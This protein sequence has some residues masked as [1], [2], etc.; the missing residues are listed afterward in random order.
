MLAIYYELDLP[1]I[2]GHFDSFLFL[3]IMS[4]TP[5]PIQSRALVSKETLYGY[6]NFYAQGRATLEPG[7]VFDYDTASE[8]GDAAVS[9]DLNKL[10]VQVYVEDPDP[11]SPTYGYLIDATAVSLIGFKQDGN[12]RVVN[13]HT[14][15][16]TF[17]VR[18]IIHL[19]PV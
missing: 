2:V 17:F 8:L 13:Q 12:V 9:Y 6:R 11:A 16:L 7:E 14:A 15:A 5:P 1:S 18:I 3:L 10:E 4:T 19:K